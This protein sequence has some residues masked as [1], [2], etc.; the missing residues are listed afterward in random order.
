MT[1]RVNISLCFRKFPFF[2]LF[3]L[4]NLTFLK[5]PRVLVASELGKC[6][7]VTPLPLFMPRTLHTI[8]ESM[9]S[10]VGVVTPDWWVKTV[11]RVSLSTSWFSSLH[12]TRWFYNLVWYYS[13]SLI[14]G[15]N[16]RPVRYLYGVWSQFDSSL[17]D[18]RTTVPLNLNFNNIKYSIIHCKF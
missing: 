16:K 3:T 7:L 17:K 18:G 4:R 1:C 13:A 5:L 10:T 2:F 15:R 14:Q 12:R 11:D 8:T 6:C 9:T